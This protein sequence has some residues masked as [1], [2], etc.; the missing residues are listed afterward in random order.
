M[1]VISI[2]FLLTT[3][4][5]VDRTK[6]ARAFHCLIQSL[7]ISNRPT[8]PE[9]QSLF[10]SMN[11]RKVVDII[12][13]DVFVGMV[14]SVLAIGEGEALISLLRKDTIVDFL[15]NY[16]IDSALLRPEC[17]S[18]DL[19]LIEFASK[20]S[21]YLTQPELAK[22]F[23]IFACQNLEEE[24]RKLPDSLDDAI[25]FQSTFIFDTSLKILHNIVEV[26]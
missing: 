7:S 24:T 25:T 16:F 8:Q 9:L 23:I 17:L 4:S 3:E 14:V 13:P 18:L 1:D 6:F 22:T 20:I 10:D 12:S 2:R 5:D 15:K 19:I 26:I 21:E 11:T